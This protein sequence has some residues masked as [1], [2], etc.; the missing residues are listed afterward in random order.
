METY[1]SLRAVTGGVLA[2]L[3]LLS[4]LAP[5]PR[6][7]AADTA[8]PNP[9]TVED[10]IGFDRDTHDVTTYL[11]VSWF[12]FSDPTGS[13]LDYAVAFGTRPCGTEV[14]GFQPVGNVSFHEASGLSLTRGQRY[15]ATVRA[16]N[17]AGLSTHVSS[18]GV[19]ILLA[20]GGTGGAP[21]AMP[22]GVC[23][24][25]L[26]P[27]D[28]GTPDS[29]TPDGGADGGTPD[30]GAPGGGTLDEEELERLDP[31]LGWGC[32]ASGGSGGL[33]LLAFSALGLGVRRRAP[34]PRR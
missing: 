26:P 20:D 8:P 2:S 32:G 25:D 24:P 10:A 13:S 5:S 3:T 33:A 9:G 15:Y 27:S 28:A 17:G 34:L 4:L 21:G 16:T 19:L 29:G 6:A 14:R 1:M 23:M 7:L 18:D 30:G 12:G 22:G 11:L 31:V